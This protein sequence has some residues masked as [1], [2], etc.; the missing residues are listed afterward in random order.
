MEDGIGVCES[1]ARER[2]RGTISAAT[3]QLC[4]CAIIADQTV[5]G[6]RADFVTQSAGGASE[7]FGV[8][9]EGSAW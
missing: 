7:E 6:V 2:R 1:I 3:F 4:F 9:R 8:G 5:V